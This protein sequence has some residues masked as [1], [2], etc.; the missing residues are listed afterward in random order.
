MGAFDAYVV[1]K[2][3]A[4]VTRRCSFCD[5]HVED[6]LEESSNFVVHLTSPMPNH[7]ELK[8]WDDYVAFI[9]SRLSV[10]PGDL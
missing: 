2:T 1:S 8:A 9:K 5:A 4:T 6:P 10:V 7:R 3:D